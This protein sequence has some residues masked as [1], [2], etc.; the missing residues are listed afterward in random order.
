MAFKFWVGVRE[1]FPVSSFEVLSGAFVIFFFYLSFGSFCVY[2]NIYSEGWSQSYIF[3]ILSCSNTIYEK[4]CI[5][6][7]S[8]IMS[9]LSYIKFLYP[10]GSIFELCMFPW[11]NLLL[12]TEAYITF[13]N[14]KGL[15]LLHCSTISEFFRI[16]SF[17]FLCEL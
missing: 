2:T 3:L 8:V 7:H 5:F 11:V 10:W 9:I 15:V 14:L 13:Y 17:V 16:F 6:P 12:I 1:T 4:V